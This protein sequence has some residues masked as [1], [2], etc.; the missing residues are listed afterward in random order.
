MELANVETFHDEE[1]YIS[2]VQISDLDVDQD[3]K[4]ASNSGSISHHVDGADGVMNEWNSKAKAD[5]RND[6]LEE[7]SINRGRHSSLGISKMSFSTPKL[8]LLPLRKYLLFSGIEK[9]KTWYSPWWITW[10]GWRLFVLLSLAA[11]VDNM[12]GFHNKKPWLNT[13]YL[14][15]ASV[16]TLTAGCSWFWLPKVLKGLESQKGPPIIDEDMSAAKKLFSAFFILNFIAAF[17]LA[18]IKVSV[19]ISFGLFGIIF[20]ECC[21][22]TVVL[23]GV[24]LVLTIETTLAK[25]EVAQ[26]LEA[27]QQCRLTRSI[28]ADGVKSIKLRSDRWQWPLN[29]LAFVAC[30]CSLCLIYVQT[31]I[32]KNGRI[33]TDLFSNRDDDDIAGIEINIEIIVV[34]MKETLLL[35]IIMYLIMGINDEADAITAEL[36]ESTWGPPGSPHDCARLDL[37]FTSTTQ[38]APIK[39]VKS[40][41]TYFSVS[42]VRPVSFDVLYFRITR[43]QVLVV[44]FSLFLAMINVINRAIDY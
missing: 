20:L 44:A 5:K 14:L 11:T 35:F 1:A 16:A 34:L 27:A 15:P 12:I 22:A 42:K 31:I 10:I 37:L 24:L 26:L 39:A 23:G 36:L 33:Q 7:Y 19:S 32:Y 9:P 17:T 30:Y 41:Y 3:S 8:P 13:F 29:S 2:G 25:K 18:S 43:D 28:Y 40:W 6:S 21:G 38:A 4:E